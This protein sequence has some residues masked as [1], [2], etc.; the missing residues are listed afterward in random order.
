MTGSDETAGAVVSPPPARRQGSVAVLASGGLD[1]AILLG[2]YLRSGSDVYPLYIRQGL[3]WE[4]AELAHLEHYLDALRGPRLHPLQI[5]EMPVGDLYGQ[6]WSITGHGVPD[7]TSADAAVFLPGRN[8]M[9]LAKAILWCHLRHIP[10]VALA[11][12][13]ANPFPDAIPEF[14]IKFQT[15]VNEAVGG[16][17]EVLRPFDRFAKDEVMRRGRGLPLHLTFS[18]IHPVAS[19]PLPLSWAPNRDKVQGRHCG[20][21]NKCAE[22][23][24]AFADARMADPTEYDS[25]PRYPNHSP[26]A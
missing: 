8:V 20:R 19:S 15:V 11:P 3:C 14:F 5:L 12:L 16:A 4:Y 9:L 21:C 25:P 22:R 6:H 18:C 26:P 17:V 23:R 24:R 7:A 10:A 1:S 13:L 2:D